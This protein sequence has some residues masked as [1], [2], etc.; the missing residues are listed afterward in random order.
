MG[1]RR[2]FLARAVLGALGA[3]CARHRP[4]GARPAYL[5]SERSVG[6]RSPVETRRGTYAIPLGE[7]PDDETEQM[8]W[9]RR[10]ALLTMPEAS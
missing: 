8:T 7:K 1:V 10:G 3:R 9:S 6:Y 5:F 4:G 2:T